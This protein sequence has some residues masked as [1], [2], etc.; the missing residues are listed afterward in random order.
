MREKI[1][2]QFNSVISRYEEC[3]AEA[4][5]FY[6]LKRARYR[7]LQKVAIKALMTAQAQNIKRIAKLLLNI[8]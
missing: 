1:E 8:Y 2:Q 4:K 6:G 7:G 5:Q 3:F